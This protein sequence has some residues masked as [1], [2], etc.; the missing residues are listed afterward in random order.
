MKGGSESES[1][2]RKVKRNKSKR[3]GAKSEI[4]ILN[5]DQQGKAD[6]IVVSFGS[7]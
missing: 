1:K 6:G 3:R 2:R 5:V 7:N 4:Q